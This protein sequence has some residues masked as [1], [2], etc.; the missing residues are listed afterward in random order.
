MNNKYKNIISVALIMSIIFGFAFW[1]WVKPSDDYSDAERR[2]LEKFPKLSLETVFAKDSFMNKFEGYATDQFPMRESFRKL[3]AAFN[4]YILSQKTINDIYIYDGYAAKLEYPADDKNIEYS[5]ARIKSLYN[6]YLKNSNV[7]LSVIPDKNFYLSKE[8]GYLSI[9]YEAFTEKITKETEFAKHI[10]ITGTLS[11]EN[12]YKTDT[13]WKQ[14][15]LI[16]TAN[17]ILAAMG[18]NSFDNYTVNEFSGDFY[19]VYCGQIALDLEPEKLSYLTNDI[20]SSLK[21]TSYDSGKPEEIPLYDFE[22]ASGK[23]GYELYLS[24]PLS[25]ITIENPRAENSRELIVFRDSFGSSIAP[26]FASSYSKVT[27]ID[28]RYIAPSALKNFVS[29]ENKDI[30]FLYSA[31]VLNNS[32]GQLLP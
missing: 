17:T 5:V 27:L 8:S 31:L 3:N 21:I 18:S 30:L 22:K 7:Y 23:D 9:D 26:L 10:D 12:Y 6:L 11:K 24:G 19:G 25:L 32:I 2:S 14:E 15:T 20:L 1:S 29:F 28:T 13:H 16:N 4:K